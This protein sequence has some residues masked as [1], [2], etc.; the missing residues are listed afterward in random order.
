MIKRWMYE[1]LVYDKIETANNLLARK[2]AI[3]MRFDVNFLIWIFVNNFTW[4]YTRKK[5]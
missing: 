1:V 3:Q 4:V 2:I 5:I